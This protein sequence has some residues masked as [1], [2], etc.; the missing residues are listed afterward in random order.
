M[1]VG[2]RGHA[3]RVASPRLP[4]A[5]GHVLPG[6]HFLK[7]WITIEAGVITVEEAL[8]QILHGKLGYVLTYGGVII[9]GIRRTE[10]GV[11]TAV[12]PVPEIVPAVARWRPP[13][14]TGPTKR[15]PDPVEHLLIEPIK[16]AVDARKDPAAAAWNDQ[17]GPA[18]LDLFG[19]ALV[20]SQTPRGH[21]KVIKC[22]EGLRPSLAR[23]APSEAQAPEP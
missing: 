10:P 21:E 17:G 14:S 7:E 20:V 1:G 8:E 16:R 5:P 13:A 9:T 23:G 18:W 19:R 22:L 3:H 12:Y 11:Y 6:R 4:Q 2:L 15:Q